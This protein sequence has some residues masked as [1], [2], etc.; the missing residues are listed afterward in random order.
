MVPLE[1]VA[2]Q[3]WLV[4]DTLPTAEGSSKQHNDYPISSLPRESGIQAR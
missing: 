4:E 2:W 3:G 1:R